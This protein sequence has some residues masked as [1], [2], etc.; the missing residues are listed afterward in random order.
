M[1]FIKTCGILKCWFGKEHAEY[2]YSLE[3]EIYD[4]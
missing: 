3:I 4:I 2:A 1:E